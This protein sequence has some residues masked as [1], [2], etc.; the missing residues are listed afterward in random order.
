MLIKPALPFAIYASLN[1]ALSRLK[2]IDVFVSKVDSL[3]EVA[4]CQTFFIDKKVLSSEANQNFGFLV[5][6]QTDASNYRTFEKFQTH[7]KKLLKKAERKPLVKRYL[8][9]LGLNHLVTQIGQELHG[10]HEEV[11]MLKQSKFEL[12]YQF[13]R[14]QIIRKVHG[15]SSDIFSDSYE[16]LRIFNQIPGKKEC[17]SSIVKT[18]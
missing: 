1:Y 9:C 7:S 5:S 2:K 8:E 3:G 11:D 6:R 10:D 4:V 18:E 17:T 15:S 12:S 14:G 13:E 16:T